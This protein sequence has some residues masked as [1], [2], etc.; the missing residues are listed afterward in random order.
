MGAPFTLIVATIC[1]DPATW[2]PID[3]S[4]RVYVPAD[5]VIITAAAAATAAP[6][7]PAF[8]RSHTKATFGD[9]FRA[10]AAI[11]T[12]SAI[13]LGVF[14]SRAAAG[15]RSI[16]SREI[17]YVCSHIFLIY[18]RWFWIIEALIVRRFA[19]R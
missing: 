9:R 18:A 7:G 6:V 8:P 10:R 4:Y 11:I 12:K 5:R 1:E 3:A 13:S 2:V 19:R 17:L 16:A 14:T 15:L